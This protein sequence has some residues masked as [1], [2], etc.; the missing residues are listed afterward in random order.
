M[1]QKSVTIFVNG[2]QQQSGDRLV[3]SR[4]GKWHAGALLYYLSSFGARSLFGLLGA[5][6]IATG[7]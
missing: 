2:L 4:V 3:Q 5:A 7:I 6:A 1:G